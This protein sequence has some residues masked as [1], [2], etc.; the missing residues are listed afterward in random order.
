MSAVIGW[1][2]FVAAFVVHVWTGSF[3]WLWFLLFISLVL[4]WDDVSNKNRYR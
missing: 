2:L 1:F 3:G 4:F